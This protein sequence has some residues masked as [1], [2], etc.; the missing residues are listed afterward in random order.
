MPALSLTI[1]K[2]ALDDAIRYERR[3][4]LMFEGHRFFD[5][6]RWMIA[7]ETEKEIY[8]Y[9][10]RKKNDGTF[11]YIVKKFH[12]RAFDAPQMYLLPIPFDEVQINK[13]CPQ[14]PGW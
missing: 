9:D 14:N 12:S 6:R 4:E 5:V 11:K 10:I 3:I 7:P 8:Y 13:N 2:E 1:T